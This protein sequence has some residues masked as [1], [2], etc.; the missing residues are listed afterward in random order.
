MP[1]DPG[2]LRA[3]IFP[4]WVNKRMGISLLA[5]QCILADSVVDS[6]TVIH[7]LIESVYLLYCLVEHSLQHI[8]RDRQNEEMHY[9]EQLFHHI[10]STRLINQSLLLLYT[11]EILSQRQTGQ[12]LYVYVSLTGSIIS[13]RHTCTCIVTNF[14]I[15]YY[16][17]SRTYLW[18]FA[19]LFEKLF[20]VFFQRQVEF[21]LLS[22]LISFPGY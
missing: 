21:F 3:F 15:I 9:F 11:A 22:F 17:N 14:S 16:F 6:V 13:G 5:L 19:G 8:S 4:R 20:A 7:E 10:T 12:T 2:H 1:S 18:E